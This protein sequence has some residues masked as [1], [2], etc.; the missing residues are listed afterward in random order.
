MTSYFH[1][2]WL[3]WHDNNGDEIEI[4]TEKFDGLKE[5]NSSLVVR[6]FIRCYSYGL[7]EVELY[8]GNWLTVVLAHYTIY[9]QLARRIYS[10]AA[11]M[12]NCI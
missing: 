9:T 11:E 6:A 1:S 2:S 4:E 12:A 7:A 8:T 3:E 10:L 5:R